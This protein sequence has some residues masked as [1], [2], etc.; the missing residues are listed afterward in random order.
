MSYS[1]VF[2]YSYPC[3]HVY[4][5]KETLAFLLPSLG[6]GGVTFLASPV[7]KHVEK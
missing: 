3:V 4:E 5:S 2:T 1:T 7:R 6:S